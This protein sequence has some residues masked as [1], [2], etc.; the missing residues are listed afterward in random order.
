MTTIADGLMVPEIWSKLI[1]R[2]FDDYGVMADC[3]N[4]DHEGEI[5]YAGDTVRIPQLGDVT[6]NTH[7]D[8]TPIVY[9]NINGVEQVL[10]I[11]QQDDW[12]FRITSIEQKQSNI[13]DLQEKY[14]ARARV[15]L[16]NKKD[17]F[18]HS[19]GFAGVD[20][21]NQIGTK[22]ATKDTIY[23]I[24]LDMYQALADSNAIGAD[25]KAD[26]GKR[27]WLIVTPAIM[28][29]IKASPEM[30]HAT[31]KGDSVIR[32]GTV[33]S[34]AGFDVKQTTLVKNDGGFKILAG[35]KEAITYANQLM[36]TQTVKDKD[37]HAIFVSG[38]NVYGAKVV[39]PK[40]L[41]SANLT[42]A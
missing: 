8:D 23:D 10:Q 33:L 30:T 6:I 22:A 37:Y 31:E 5:R 24:C 14:A 17:T 40:A 39:Q 29:L 26:G 1:L 38:L 21:A 27:P 3:V 25:G 28:K 42:V 4:T 13:K 15:A 19:L 41:A 2:N 18:L 7:D 12:G 34:Y 32:K 11:D 36:D 16:I 9:Q 20:S 35:T